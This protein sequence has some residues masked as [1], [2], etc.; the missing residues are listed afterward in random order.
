[1]AEPARKSAFRTTVPALTRIPVGAPS[2][3]NKGFATFT[4]ALY[5][6]VSVQQGSERHRERVGVPQDLRY[7]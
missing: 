7:P 3:L 1:M 5:Q 6:Q 2:T 4:A